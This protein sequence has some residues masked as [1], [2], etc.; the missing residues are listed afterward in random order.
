MKKVIFL[1]LCLTPFGA[2]AMDGEHIDGSVVSQE[3]VEE[4]NGV[5]I[6]DSEEDIKNLVEDYIKKDIMLKGGF[7]IEER[8]SGKILRLKYLGITGISL[9]E[10]GDKIVTAQFIGDGKLYS[11]NFFLS[12]S[13][14]GNMEIFK[15]SVVQLSKTGADTSRPDR[16]EESSSK[17]KSKDKATKENSVKQK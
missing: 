5:M 10:D 15:I 2:F 12:G 8:P 6:Q 4:N 11:L 9:P 3:N 1:S 7:F 17:E 16:K 14:W 13:D